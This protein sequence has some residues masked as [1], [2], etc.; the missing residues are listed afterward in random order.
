[1]LLLSPLYF[2]AGNDLYIGKN[3]IYIKRIT[4]DTNIQYIRTV[5]NN[6]ST[7]TALFNRKDCNVLYKFYLDS[8]NIC[9]KQIT[10]VP[11][12][13]YTSVES[14][15][16]S[17]YTYVKDNLYFNKNKS[18]HLKVSKTNMLGFVC[19]EFY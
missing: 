19:L 10:I 14:L 7:S 18:N 2:L 16:K 6:D 13:Y 4:A 3:D 5:K 8:D 11:L 17:D 12:K 9:T 15:L 1:M